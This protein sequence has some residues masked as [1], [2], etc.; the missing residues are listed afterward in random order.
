MEKVISI[1]IK[2]DFGFLKKPDTNDPIYLTF[3]MLHKPA[4]LG[5]FGAIL[6]LQGFL[7]AR[8]DEKKSKKKT[9]KQTVS[10]EELLPE[11]YQR[12]KNLKIG[13]QPLRFIEN[14]KNE[15][16]LDKNFNGN[17]EKTI[18]KYNN[19][20]G[21][22]NLDGGNLI[23]VEQTLIKPNYRCY[24]LVEDNNDINLQLYDYL[25]NFKAE[26]L[27]YLGK[28][29]FSLWWDSF[30]EY[31]VKPFNSA[32]ES[33]SIKTIFIKSGLVKEGLMEM[34]DIELL[35]GKEGNTFIYFEN[36]P[37]SYNL[38]LMQYDYQPFSY[39]DWSLKQSYSVHNLYELP[40]N[41]IIQLF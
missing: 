21:Y 7:E 5:I 34:T 16:E 17:F 28:N 3:N 8:K 38:N 29:D 39:T 4:L 6:G 2:A 10:R 11:Y 41:E 14:E 30:R 19:G 36:L 20:V 18:I 1:D 32:E 23:V 9:D 35:M 13:I 31:E 12:L 24:I 40:N 22:A 26:Y 15:F 37:V 27:P 25:K 33:F